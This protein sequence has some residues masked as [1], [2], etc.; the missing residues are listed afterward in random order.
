MGTA[1]SAHPPASSMSAVVKINHLGGESSTDSAQSRDVRTVICGSNEDRSGSPQRSTV[2][3]KYVGFADRQVKP[4][5]PML[6]SSFTFT[7][8]ARINTP[9]GRAAR[10]SI[11]V[12]TRP[13][14]ANGRRR[15]V[16]KFYTHSPQASNRGLQRGTRA[17]DYVCGE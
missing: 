7:Q 13:S 8:S 17:A 2:K 15:Q 5:K 6:V 14:S 4:A 16:S 1:A 3:M 11:P 12:P 9:P 10:T